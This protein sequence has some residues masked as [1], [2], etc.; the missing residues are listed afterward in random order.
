MQ[1]EVK[2]VEL[3]GAGCRAASGEKNFI[4]VD[5]RPWVSGVDWRR[6]YSIY[7]LDRELS[8]VEVT[9]IL[10]KRALTAIKGMH[11]PKAVKVSEYPVYEE[12][13]KKRGDIIQV[14]GRN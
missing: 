7:K 6:Y 5:K 9:W 1:E 14:F 8:E 13:H 10:E 4:Y 12:K 11:L 2:E 3:E